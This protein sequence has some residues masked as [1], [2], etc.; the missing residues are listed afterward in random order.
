VV[1]INLFG[2]A[3][4]E[5][6]RENVM[7][8]RVSQNKVSAS[9][10]ADRPDEDLLLSYADSGDSLLFTELVMRYERELYGYLHRFLGH[11]ELAKDVLQATFLQLH[12]KC[13][14]FQPG[15]PLRPWLFA[16]ATNQAIDALRSQR[17]HWGP[18][19]DA[20]LSGLEGE[21]A[22]LSENLQGSRQEPCADAHLNE[23]RAGVR[24]AV[25]QLP[26]Q[27]R[28]IVRLI[29]FDGLKYREAAEALAL[30][31]GTVKSRMHSAFDK[32]QRQ[33]HYLAS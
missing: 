11:R 7:V 2:W 20:A 33:L 30:P 3:S 8:R 31:L 22:T 13:D 26:L 15:R 23:C 32:L 27:L 18:S 12:L 29:Y 28:Q 25:D 4:Q 6:E 5:E 1:A 9:T 10:L 14:S 19:I 24:Q 16:I 21:C 17:K